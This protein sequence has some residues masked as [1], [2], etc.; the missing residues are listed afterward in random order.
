MKDL[1][2]RSFR[3]S[4]LRFRNL[5]KAARRRIHLNRHSRGSRVQAGKDTGF[6]EFTGMAFTPVTSWRYWGSDMSPGVEGKELTPLSRCDKEQRP[7]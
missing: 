7:N 1:L 6:P 4:R 3:F 2:A 5:F